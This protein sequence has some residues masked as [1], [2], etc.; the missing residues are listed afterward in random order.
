MVGLVAGD[1]AA[2][3]DGER[4]VAEDGTAIGLQLVAV[5]PP[6][7][8][9]RRIKR[10]IARRRNV[11]EPEEVRT[12]RVALDDRPV[13]VDRDLGRHRR[14][15]VLAGG[16]VVDVR[17]GEGACRRQDDRVRTAARRTVR[18]CR[19]VVVGVDDR[20]AQR[21]VPVRR[22][23]DHTRGDVDRR[24]VRGRAGGQRHRQQRSGR[25]QRQPPPPQPALVPRQPAEP[26]AE[27]VEPRA[28]PVHARHDHAGKPGTL[29]R[30]GKLG[31][32]GGEDQRVGVWHAV[33]CRR[34][35]FGELLHDDGS[36][37]SGRSGDAVQ[38]NPTCGRR[39]APTGGTAPAERRTLTI[40][41]L[42][43]RSDPRYGRT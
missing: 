22:D 30:G 19:R 29:G 1:H 9:G 18:V 17:H 14:Q 42:T 6:I 39:T 5:E 37:T 7:A 4:A 13:A 41:A 11:E 32:P 36:W 34:G 27:P 35:G 3:R 28:Q 31:A 40:N 26:A 43:Q 21:A 38:R 33:G 12:G 20:L 16:H 8:H 25:R 15:P 23:H 10:Q 2:V 24:R